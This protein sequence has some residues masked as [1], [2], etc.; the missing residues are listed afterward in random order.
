MR[1]TTAVERCM[2]KAGRISDS[3][4]SLLLL[5]PHPKAKVS[6]GHHGSERVNEFELKLKTCCSHIQ[7]TSLEQ[8]SKAIRWCQQ[9]HTQSLTLWSQ[10]LGV[11]HPKSG[12]QSHEG[13]RTVKATLPRETLSLLKLS[14]PASWLQ[15]QENK[16][17]N[18][19]AL[20][21]L[22]SRRHHSSLENSH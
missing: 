6:A 21:C 4:S 14:S 10:A 8:P 3:C 13:A 18:T 11:L 5:A 15:M 20:L 2:W 16:C 19:L 9:R 7:R 22:Q 1:K 12:K 17:H